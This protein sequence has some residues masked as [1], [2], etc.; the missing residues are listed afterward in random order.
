M[1][2]TTVTREVPRVPADTARRL[3]S[4]MFAEDPE[5][6][7]CERNHGHHKYTLI[8]VVYEDG[9]TRLVSFCARCGV[10]QCGLPVVE[11]DP[12]SECMLARGHSADRMHRDSHNRWREVAKV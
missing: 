4:F 3:Y 11:T 5:V 1:D 12:T 10:P 9:T 2:T 8:E 7:Q 6:R